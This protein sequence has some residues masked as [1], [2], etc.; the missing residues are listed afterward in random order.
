MLLKLLK[1]ERLM[2]DLD[3]CSRKV[4]GRVDSLMKNSGQDTSDTQSNVGATRASRAGSRRFSSRAGTLQNTGT[5]GMKK[6][7][8]Q[9]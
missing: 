2:K 4:E 1:V 9:M 6:F 3:Q 8:S 7:R 5:M